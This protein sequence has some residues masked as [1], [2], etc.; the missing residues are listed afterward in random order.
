MHSLD[1]IASLA[2]QAFFLSTRQLL[3]PVLAATVGGAAL[4][5]PA[6]PEIA[7][8]PAFSCSAPS[9]VSSLESP[10]ARTAE[11]L[12]GKQALTIV[13]IGSSSTA[14]AGASSASGS[15]PSKLAIELA[16][17]LP[18]LPVS[19]INRG[20]N[21]EEAADMLAR[22]DRDVL[23]YQP[24]LVI[25][26]IGTNALVRSADMNAFESLIQE[27]LDRLRRQGA[28]VILM[29]PQF[30][31]VVLSAPDHLRMVNL[32]EAVGRRNHVAVFH[33]FE[34][35]RRWSESMKTGYSSLIA[36][37][38]LHMNDASYAC[39]ASQLANAIL[40]ASTL[41]KPAGTQRDAQQAS[42]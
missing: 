16:N 25:W 7:V 1:S 6:L 40:D 8:S 22:F 18:E 3:I 35:M 19:V 13:A 39:L 31:P 41:P 28:D 29:D 26:Q 38:G 14:G 20:I 17:R 32:I 4:A 30:A 33:R 27:G 9:E 11:H 34:M 10:L 37:D 36:P 24:D 5:A 12:R 15:Y 2:K 23:A 21:G 42:R